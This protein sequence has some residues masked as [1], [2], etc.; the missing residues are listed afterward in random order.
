MQN[1]T[2]NRAPLSTGTPRTTTSATDCDPVG[3][4]FFSRPESVNGVTR[5]HLYRIGDP[6]PIAYSANAKLI[7]KLCQELNTHFRKEPHAHRR[8]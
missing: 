2:N 5:C 1:T 8:K 7:E 6:N 4:L 3:G